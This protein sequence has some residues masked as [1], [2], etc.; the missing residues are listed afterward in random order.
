MLNFTDKEVIEMHNRT[1]GRIVNTDISEKEYN[2]AAYIQRERSTII[3]NNN[4]I[5]E[6]EEYVCGGGII[7]DKYK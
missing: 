6:V 1:K 7:S 5:M 4:A 2:W 3:P